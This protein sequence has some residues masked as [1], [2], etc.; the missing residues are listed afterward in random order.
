MNPSVAVVAMLAV[1]GAA[2]GVLVNQLSIRR[3]PKQPLPFD[4]ELESRLTDYATS[5]PA[6]AATHASAAE[7]MVDSTCGNSYAAAARNHAPALTS[8]ESRPK[9]DHSAAD[10]DL[11]RLEALAQDRALHPGAC[12]YV[13]STDP[14]H[15][16]RGPIHNTAVRRLAVSLA[17]AGTAVLAAWVAP[18]VWAFLA[19]LTLGL[20][21]WIVALVDHDTMFVDLGAWW[22]G[23]AL[24]GVLAAASAIEQAGVS[25]VWWALAAGVLWWALFEGLNLVYKTFRGMDGV[26]G[27]DG[28]IALPATFVAVAVSGSTQVALWGVLA[29]LALAV[30]CS[31]A[32]IAF[33]KQ[34]RRDAFALGPFLAAGWQIALCLWAFGA[35]V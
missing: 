13:L 22:A 26:G 32:L 16:V 35:L 30:S 19:I 24:A 7:W 2:C 21:G 29:G 5:H 18:D 6:W 15:L 34:G 9:D 3:S 25:R 12:G 20:T 31:L 17:C 4:P 10:A 8:N 11:V 27:G 23:S 33:R 14:P 1:A 28:M